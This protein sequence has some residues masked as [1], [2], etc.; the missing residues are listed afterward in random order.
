MSYFDIYVKDNWE[1]KVKNLLESFKD[2]P[3]RFARM[4]KLADAFIDHLQRDETEFGGW[5][6]DSKRPFGNSSVYYDLA[7]ILDIE[8]P[9]YKTDKYNDMCSYLGELYGDLGV[10]LRY[11]WLAFRKREPENNKREQ[12]RVSEIMN[13]WD[14]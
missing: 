2:D 13:S 8:M 6:V 10:F 1:T 9:D 7:E 12:D 5:G 14:Y 4:E 11:K 3:D